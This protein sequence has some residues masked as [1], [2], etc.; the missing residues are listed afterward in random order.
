[1]PIWLKQDFDTKENYA[2]ARLSE[3]YAKKRNY[4]PIIYGVVIEIYSPDFRSA[5]INN[6]DKSQISTL[7][8]CL[9]K[10]GFTKQEIWRRIGDDN[11]YENFKLRYNKAKKESKK[12]INKIKEEIKNLLKR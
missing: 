5:K 4:E 3:F 1:M 9:E 11:N 8:E 2:K 6:V 10:Q 12:R 7:T